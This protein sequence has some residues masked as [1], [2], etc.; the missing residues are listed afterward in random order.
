M[1]ARDDDVSVGLV[2]RDLHMMAVLG[3]RE[4]TLEEYDALLQQAGLQRALHTP[5]PA[6][7]PDV[8]EAGIA[9]WGEAPC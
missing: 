3:G 2:A 8:I 1:P 9:Q 6:H 4:R 7:A 5:T